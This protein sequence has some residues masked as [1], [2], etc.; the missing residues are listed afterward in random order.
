M[1]YTSLPT[2]GC[3]LYRSWEAVIVGFIGGILA[4]VTMPLFDRAHIDDPVGAVAVHGIGGFWGIIA[5]G[6]FVDADTLDNITNGRAG[7]F[8]GRIWTAEDRL[9]TSHKIRRTVM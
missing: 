7:L 5:I 9:L 4:V 8:K 1:K 6:L 3:A 2:A